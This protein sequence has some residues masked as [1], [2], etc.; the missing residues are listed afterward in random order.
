VGWCTVE[1]TA[2]TTVACLATLR[3][4]LWQTVATARGFSSVAT[5]WPLDQCFTL[6]TRCRIVAR[7]GF[8]PTS[9]GCPVDPHYDWH[10]LQPTP[11]A[12]NN[13]YEHLT[14]VSC[15]TVP[16][17]RIICC[18]ELRLC[19]ACSSSLLHQQS[20]VSSILLNWFDITFWQWRII[21]LCLYQFCCNF[22][23]W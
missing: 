15:R 4:Y 23:Q 16:L 20:R 22:D 17:T 19:F 14:S 5:L 21:A 8:W 3:L 2:T 10:W 6:I 9:A 1:G 13:R 11:E 18:Y 7:F 12:D